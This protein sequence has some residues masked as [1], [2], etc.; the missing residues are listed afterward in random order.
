MGTGRVRIPKK[1]TEP[2]RVAGYVRISAENDSHSTKQKSA[3]LRYVEKRKLYVANT[4]L[5]RP[6]RKHW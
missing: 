4:Y 6:Q 1:R 5:D 2:A 3:I